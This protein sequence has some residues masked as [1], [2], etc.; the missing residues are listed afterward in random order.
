MT[1][2]RLLFLSAFALAACPALAQTVSDPAPL[3]DP[4][5][6][7]GCEAS[8]TTLPG[9]DATRLFAILHGK[10]GASALIGAKTYHVGDQLGARRLVRIETDKVIFE[11]PSGESEMLLTPRAGKN[12]K[13]AGNP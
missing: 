2:I 10:K 13:P 9:S 5:Q 1:P 7:V 11:G 4:T 12:R 3:R 8:A 6:P